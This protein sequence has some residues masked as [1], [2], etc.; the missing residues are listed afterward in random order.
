MTPDLVHDCPEC[1]D[2]HIVADCYY[3]NGSC[4]RCVLVTNIESELI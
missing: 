2:M 1:R 4:S 3:K